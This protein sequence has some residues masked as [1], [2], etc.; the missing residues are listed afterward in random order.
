MGILWGE[1]IKK[2][3]A[4]ERFFPLSLVCKQVPVH[5]KG[6]QEGLWNF[7]LGKD[8]MYFEAQ[9]FLRE[10]II[11]KTSSL[12][13][14]SLLEGWRVWYL[15]TV[16]TFAFV[17]FPLLIVYLIRVRRKKIKK[18]VLKMISRVNSCRLT[19]LYH[20]WTL[21]LVKTASLTDFS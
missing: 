16:Y 8:A 20:L 5:Y 21:K 12:I 6:Y 14:S 17:L 10:H 1:S 7:D 4:C 15:R 13:L 3:L 11:G 19:K 9:A 2:L 18:S